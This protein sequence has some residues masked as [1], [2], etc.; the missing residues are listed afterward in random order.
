MR[1]QT[2]NLCDLWGKHGRK[3]APPHRRAYERSTQLSAVA[4]VAAQHSGP[5]RAEHAPAL[6]RRRQSGRS[7]LGVSHH[8]PRSESLLLITLKLN[9]CTQLERNSMSAINTVPEL[10]RA[11]GVPHPRPAVRALARAIG[12]LFGIRCPHRCVGGGSRRSGRPARRR[13]LGDAAQLA[14]V[15]RGV[16][17]DPEGR[18]RVRPDQPGVH[19]AGGGVRRRCTRRRSRSSPTAMGPRR[20]PV[21]AARRSWR[22]CAT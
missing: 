2:L 17:G 11:A 9:H 7:A 22:G 5:C 20:S 4:L 8:R 21:S 15:P 10:L 1:R 14:R 6:V 18:G 19:R 3:L 13:R 16:V 12:E